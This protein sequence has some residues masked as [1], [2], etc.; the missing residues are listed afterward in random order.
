MP[1]SIDCFKT[2]ATFVYE[3]RKNL[4]LLY[5]SKMIKYILFI[6]R[7]LL[8]SNKKV[9]IC[10]IAFI[11]IQYLLRILFNTSPP[12]DQDRIVEEISKEVSQNYLK[13]YLHSQNLWKPMKEEYDLKNSHN[14]RVFLNSRSIESIEKK[15]YLIVEYTK[16]MDET[17]YCQYFE[18]FSPDL[19]TQHTYIDECPYKNCKFTCDKSFIDHA[20]V[21][22][23]HE[24]DL[25][26]DVSK[27]KNYYNELKSKTND[28]FNQIWLLWNDEAN[29]VNSNLDAFKFNWTMS[30]R[31][32][33][34]VF[35]CSYGCIYTKSEEVSDDVLNLKKEYLKRQRQAL[36]FISNCDSKLRLELA[37][38]FKTHFPLKIY[39]TCA[40]YVASKM[41]NYLFNYFKNLLF[42]PKCL[43]N[44]VCE[45]A[46]FNSSLFY[47]SFESKNCSN[48]ITEKLWRILNTNM[49]PVVFQP[50]KIFYELNA[51]PDSFIHAQDFDYDPVKLANYLDSVSKDFNLYLKHQ[52]WKYNFDIVYI[53]KQVE[54]RRLCQLCTR[55]NEDTSRTY[56]ESVS[57]WF[58][59]FCIV[60]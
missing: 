57:E 19:A 24:S 10:I 9:T 23:F 22:L 21:L 15:E 44:S 55:L 42:Q 28:R 27:N 59:K 2:K 29:P 51:P 7:R 16:I 38:K 25:K 17:K 41:E 60:N 30:Y 46:E 48:Y 31:H 6:T 58:N 56:Y 39:G 5:E 1:K 54:N 52:K 35:D 33:S 36:S 37:S 26:K 18:K 40:K 20:D 11:V 4:A 43:R 3:L 45:A 47:L 53:G 32:D 8:C 14:K 50:N 49:I 12:N 13:D 34:E